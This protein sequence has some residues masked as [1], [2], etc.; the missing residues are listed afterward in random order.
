MAYIESHQELARH[1]KT[2]RLARVLGISLPTAVGHLQFLW[3][4]AM[5]YAQD[6][7][8]SRYDAADIADAAL[9][10]GDAEVFLEA[11][12]DCGPGGGAG[13]VDRTEAGRAL[14]DWH[15]Y[16]GKLHAERRKNAERM[17]A[18]RAPVAQEEVVQRTCDA[19]VSHVART[20]KERR[21]EER[22][23]EIITHPHT[24]PTVPQCE[25][26]PDAADAAAGGER[27]EP[28]VQKPRRRPTVARPQSR[29]TWLREVP[30]GRERL[31]DWFEE[32]FWRAYPRREAA[33][34][35]W[36]ALQ[37][38]ALQVGDPERLL[39]A[40]LT[41]LEAY[42]ASAQWQDATKVPYPATWLRRVPWESDP[43]TPHTAQVALPGG[44]A[45]TRRGTA[46]E[47]DR[48]AESIARTVA[49]AERHGLVEVAA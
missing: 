44:G 18:K 12:I 42:R 21:G 19:R 16:G 6:G 34:D 2:R 40:I 28:V 10:E 41:S 36:K 17:A 3:W 46:S 32:C 43:P 45:G 14:H 48:I 38:V 33:P 49:A 47:A 39:A 24:P 23:E 27:R 26:E 7:D 13:F 5:D 37:E 25:P 30:A 9:W 22:R 11:L 31:A 35:A 4:W 20:L 1:P 8:L 29:F 15:E